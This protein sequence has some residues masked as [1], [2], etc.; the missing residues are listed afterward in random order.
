MEPLADPPRD[1]FKKKEALAERAMGEM[2]RFATS[3][4]ISQ[5][6]AHP[7]GCE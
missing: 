2:E 3:V 6:E 5:A 4:G 7:S 1:K